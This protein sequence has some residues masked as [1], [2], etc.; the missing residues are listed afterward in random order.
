[1]PTQA[2]SKRQCSRNKTHTVYPRT[3][4]V[5]ISCTPYVVSSALQ[6]RI[7]FPY[8]E[9]L[10]LALEQISCLR[11]P[12]IVVATAGDHDGRVCMW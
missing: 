10:N 1:M 3:D 9:S 6:P 8:T 11:F 4:P 5:V 2:G 12:Q 7:T